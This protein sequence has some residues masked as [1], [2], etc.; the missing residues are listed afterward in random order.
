MLIL[1]PQKLGNHYKPEE[2]L[3]KNNIKSNIYTIGN[4]KHNA[5]CEKIVI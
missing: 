3:T 5:I 4:R 1:P 2:Y